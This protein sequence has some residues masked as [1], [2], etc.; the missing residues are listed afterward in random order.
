MRQPGAQA[1]VGPFQASTSVVFPSADGWSNAWWE[2]TS[3]AE[4]AP[5]YSRWQTAQ[6]RLSCAA[7]MTWL[8]GPDPAPR[9]GAAVWEE[10]A[11]ENR[12]WMQIWASIPLRT[13]ASPPNQPQPCSG[14]CQ[15][16]K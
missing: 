4:S 6:I 13:E 5:R 10:G 7:R 12:L 3:A 1:E 9:E 15:E 2:E 16:G 14:P 8:E 11:W